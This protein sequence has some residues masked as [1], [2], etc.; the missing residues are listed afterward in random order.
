VYES[1]AL[2]RFLTDETPLVIPSAANEPPPVPI[3]KRPVVTLPDA[4]RECVLN[5][6]RLKAA[7]EQIRG[8]QA[9]YI[10]ESL[11]P[12][13][14]LFTDA[15]LLPITMANFDNQAG[16]PQYDALLTVPIDW[17]VF[18]KRVAAQ[19]AA[20]LNIDVAQA[21]FADQI[22]REVALAVDS[23]YDALE[24]DI[25][26][27][28]AEKDIEALQQLEKTAKE[29]GKTP[30]E[31]KRVQL[32]TLDA[33]R[34]LR[35]RRAAAETT[36]SKLQMHMG[37]PPDTPDFVVRGTLAIKASATA[38]TLNQAWALAEQNR[39]DLVAARRS[40]V[41][42]EAAVERERKRAMPQLS[43]TSGLDYQDQYRITG[44][45]NATLWTI[46]VNSTLPFT[47]RNQGRILAAEAA[48]RQS[49]AN[50]GAA[51]ADAR[52]EVEQAV[53]EYN[54]A[55]NGVTGE[56]IASLRTAHEVRDAT[57]EAYRKGTKD[58]VD[59]LDAE[60]AFRDRVRNT[61]GNLTDYWQALNRL[62]SVVGQRVLN[63]VE[64]EKDTL[65]EE[66]NPPKVVP[67]P[68]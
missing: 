34:D 31:V 43:V 42:S 47:D 15:Q 14:Q 62:N 59:T 51:I 21:A 6:L 46:A 35:K 65:L 10:T 57:L 44:F 32:A 39:P 1:A 58:L 8:A 9:D 37:R 30:I 64:A 4:V 33:Q 53:A 26:V 68:K 67:P 38:L 56:D 23:F 19:A 52:V 36:K 28:L 48:N 27:K 3:A 7:E 66:A 11:I 22:R 25:A 61:L 45:R 29:F 17:F 2:P 18:G 5:N 12:N 50:L 13:P 49:R 60:R 63:A 20:R 55:V 41:A 24:A 16:P 54:E 40:V